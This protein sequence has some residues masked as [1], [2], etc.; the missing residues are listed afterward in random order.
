MPGFGEST[1]LP[2]PIAVVP[3]GHWPPPM[4]VE[5][6]PPSLPVWLVI[7]Y[8]GGLWAQTANADICSLRSLPFHI[9]ARNL[10]CDLGKALS[11]NTDATSDVENTPPLK[12]TVPIG[13]IAVACD[14]VC[15][16]FAAFANCY[17]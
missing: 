2:P 7:T 1:L 16:G 6:P 4:S 17:E 12:S 10:R 8:F 13:Q 14:C 5:G 11:T 9:T 3:V 15:A